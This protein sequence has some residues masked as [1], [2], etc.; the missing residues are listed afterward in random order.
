MLSFLGILTPT[1]LAKFKADDQRP[2]FGPDPRP[3]RLE[4]DSAIV[5]GQLPPVAYQD[6][7]P[8][9]ERRRFVHLL[10]P[11]FI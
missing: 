11:P 9:D 8:D 3:G 1:R 6:L 5:A 4:H 10:S 7:D 2:F